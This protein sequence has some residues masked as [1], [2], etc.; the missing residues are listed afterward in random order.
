MVDVWHGD[1]GVTSGSGSDVT[2]CLEPE[3]ESVNVSASVAPAVVAASTSIP[4][5]SLDDCLDDMHGMVVSLA[6]FLNT[7]R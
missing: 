4:H 3:V 5:R 2:E 6:F 7:D 1:D